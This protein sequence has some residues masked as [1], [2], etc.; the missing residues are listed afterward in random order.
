MDEIVS[1][2][3]WVSLQTKEQFIE[4]ASGIVQQEVCLTEPSLKM[5]RQ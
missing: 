4:R 3:I 2:N 5:T 1:T